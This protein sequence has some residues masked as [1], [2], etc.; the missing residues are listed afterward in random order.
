MTTEPRDDLKARVQSQFGAAA[1]DYA[2]SDI[3]ARG[4]SLAAMLQEAQPQP[5]WTVLDVAAGAGHTAFALAPHVSRAVAVDL[6]EAMVRKTLE[7]ATARGLPNVRAAQADAERLPFAPR[8]FD[9]V[10][11]RLAFHHFP[12]PDNALREFARVLRPGGVLLLADSV[13]V[14]EPAAAAWYNAYEK[15]RDPSHYRVLS[16]TGLCE[17]LAA[18]GFRV[19][20]TR[21]LSREVE[22]Q[23]WTDRQRVSDADKARLLA[24]LRDLPGALRP[25]LAPRRAR[26]TLYF[27]LAEAV[28]LARLEQPYRPSRAA[29]STKSVATTSN[30]GS[31][32]RSR[33]LSGPYS[34]GRGT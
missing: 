7:L 26:G 15:L 17:L 19:S 14:D 28:L 25:V 1:A 30:A 29:R 6:T 32:V 16:V 34:S 11:C 5:D 31:G 13:T 9:A 22:F 27:R 24:M 18:A 12:Q 8:S 3:H 10:A 4:E 33:P 21:E 20:A 2:T 23:E